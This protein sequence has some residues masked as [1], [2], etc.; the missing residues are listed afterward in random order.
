MAFQVAEQASC[1]D[2][3]NRIGAAIRSRVKMFGGALEPPR[4]S[5]RVFVSFGKGFNI[6]KP[7]RLAAV[8]AASVLGVVSSVAEACRSLVRHSGSFN[9][10]KM[11]PASR[12][13]DTGTS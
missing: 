7:H 11:N 4:L 3:P 1:G 10:L 13:S 9:G 2:I 8:A 12:L 5:Q 6:L